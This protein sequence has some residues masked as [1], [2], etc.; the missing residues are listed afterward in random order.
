[1]TTSISVARGCMCGGIRPPGA[2]S[3]RAMPTPRVLRP[4]ILAGFTK[5][6]RRLLVFPGMLRP[7]AK[8]SSD[9]T[10]F[11][12]LQNSPFTKTTIK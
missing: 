1:M 10:S 4:G 5:E 3:I 7:E 6:P 12:S 11:G 8:K 2:K 9:V